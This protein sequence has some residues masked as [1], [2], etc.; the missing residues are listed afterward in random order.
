MGLAVDMLGNETGEVARLGL[1]GAVVRGRLPRVPGEILVSDKLAQD[2]D[3]AVGDTA[4]FIGVTAGGG[5]AVRN[6]VLAGTLRFGVSM[7]DRNLML[8]DLADIQYALDMEDG[9]GEILGLLP[10]QIFD[11]KAADAVVADF[12]IPYRNTEDEYAPT[13][14][15]FRDQHGMGE[16]MDFA[17][18]ELLIIVSLF[19][20]VMSIVL[21]NSGLMSGLRRY[22]EMGV[23]LAMG[24]GKGR[25]YRS[26]AYES[27]AIGAAASVIG[28]ACGMGVCYY[29]QEVGLDITQW[30]RGGGAEL[31]IAIADVIR[32]RVTPEGFFVGFIPGLLSTVLGALASGIGIFKRQT[33]TLFKELEV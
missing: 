2:L 21:W 13:M 30:L 8:A 26:L 4:T 31:N 25:V 20:F 33:S 10:N 27:L 17:R 32:T 19:I 22:G 7:M 18:I 11:R 24:E 28:A 1:P 23:R 5:M 9:V 16:M 15:T 29:L 6:F 12:E 3:A 14:I